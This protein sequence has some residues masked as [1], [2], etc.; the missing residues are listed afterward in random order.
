MKTSTLI[1]LLQIAGLMH[2]GLLCAGLMMP[3]VVQLRAHLNA[4][5]VFIRQLFW[6]YYT[7]IGLCLVSFGCITLTLAG[8][9]AAGGTLAR[10][11]CGFFAAFW[12]L[13]LIVAT[14]IFDLSPYLTN[15]YRRLGYHAINVVFIY[16]PVVYLLAAWKG[17]R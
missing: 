6:V 11:L 3:G 13:R 2:L 7:F 15:I 8:T 1:P 14:F 16:L 5:P 10:A 17:A 9:L 4:V 12:T